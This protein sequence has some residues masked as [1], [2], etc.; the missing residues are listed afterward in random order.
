MRINDVTID[1]HDWPTPQLAAV[2]ELLRQRAVELDWLAPDAA[3]EAIDAAIERVL[4]EEV[5]VPEP[6]V[7]ECQRWYAAHRARYRNGELVHARHILF[8]VTPGTPV[9]AVRS[10]AEAMLMELRANPDA[11]AERARAKSN[12]PSG[13]QGGQLG[14]LARGSTVPEFEKAV[15]EGDTIGVLPRLVQTRHGF[16]IVAVDQRIPGEPLP[17][18]AVSGKIADELRAASEQRALGQYVRLLAADAKLEGVDLNA[19]TSPLVQ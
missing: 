19:A 16:H 13:A 5:D 1:A 10:V 17:F 4:A 15:F 2:H 18:E 14:Q 11:F 12:C 6:T 3:G 8:Q 7:E 9:A